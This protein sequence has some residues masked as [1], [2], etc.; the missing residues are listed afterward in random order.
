MPFLPAFTVNSP[1]TTCEPRLGAT[2]ANN[3]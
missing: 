2:S 3:Q 1:K